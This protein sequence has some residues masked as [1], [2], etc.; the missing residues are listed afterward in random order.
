ML[1][2]HEEIFIITKIIS[3]L[4]VKA[5]L[6]GVSASTLLHPQICLLSYNQMASFTSL[7]EGQGTNSFS[8]PAGLH[9]L[10]MLPSP[11]C[12]TLAL[13]LLQLQEP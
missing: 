9:H 8:K 10:A 11:F 2:V 5:L 13:T 4:D 1:L 12:L 6:T 3:L 7:W